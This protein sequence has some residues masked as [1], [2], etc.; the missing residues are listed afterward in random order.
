MALSFAE[1]SEV[2]LA[3]AY[4]GSRDG[5]EYTVD[6]LEVSRVLGV[7]EDLGRRAARLLE[8]RGL[9]Q[10]IEGMGAVI[11][12]VTP[13]GH[14]FVERGGTTGVIRRYQRDRGS[15]LIVNSP[16][17]NIINAPVAGDVTN[18]PVSVGTTG[19]GSTVRGGIE[20]AVVP[21][22]T[23][24]R[25]LVAELQK[26]LASLAAPHDVKRDVEADLAAI[27][28]QASK[29]QPDVLVVRPMLQA[30]QRSLAV[31][32][33]AGGALGFINLVAS[34]LRALV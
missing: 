16:G 9:I 27:A 2:M 15:F 28:A 17:T 23:N 1:L 34:A 12:H 29:S 21:D 13:E 32:D 10:M 22:W 11:G 20:G 5:S 8:G 30:V 26:G 33:S 19:S 18:A 25:E 6:F 4:E 14:M 31:L 7:N 3:R 24:L